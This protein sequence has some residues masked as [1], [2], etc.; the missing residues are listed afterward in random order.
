MASRFLPQF[1]CEGSSVFYS[2]TKEN[3]ILHVPAGS[4]DAYKEAFVW[5]DFFNIQEIPD[6]C[7]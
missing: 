3:G 2:G 4:L 7:G 5:K 6:L 1:S